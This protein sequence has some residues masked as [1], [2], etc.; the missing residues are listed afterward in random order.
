MARYLTGWNGVGSKAY[1]MHL[2]MNNKQTGAGSKVGA[3]VLSKLGG[4]V[5]GANLR[6]AAHLRTGQHGIKK[7]YKAEK[8]AAKAQAKLKRLQAAAA[9][10]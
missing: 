3:Y 8:K 10:K 5:I 9:A 2:A 7:Q 4:R 1:Q 6:K